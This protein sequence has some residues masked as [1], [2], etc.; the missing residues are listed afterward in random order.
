MEKALQQAS[1]LR[2]SL[3]LADGLDAP[4]QVIAVSNRVTDK[5]GA[6]GRLILGIQGRSGQLTLLRDWE[7]LRVLNQ[8][9]LKAEAA[10]SLDGRGARIQSWMNEVAVGTP[11]ILRAVELPFVS[12]HVSELALLWVD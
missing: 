11:D 10:A 6:T 4:L 3:C 7:V 1:R 12:F 5:A 2:G 8:C 9:S